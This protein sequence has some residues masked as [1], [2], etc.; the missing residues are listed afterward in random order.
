[1]PRW[2]FAF[3]PLLL[4]G[5]ASAAD[6]A[7]GIAA[8]KAVGREGSGNEAAAAGWKAVT[9]A[10][11]DALFPVLVA[12][13][14]ATPA[15][16]NWLRSTLDAIIEGEKKAGRKLP[17]AELEAFATDVKKPSAA[18]RIAFELVS[19]DA[20]VK[21]KL[22]AGML[23]DPNRELRR[24]AVAFELNK[25]Q[26]MGSGKAAGLKK[27]FAHAR[28]EDQ[29]TKLAEMLEPKLE[30]KDLAAHFGYITRWHVVGPFE[31]V[32]PAGF[33][34]AFAPEK[35]VKLDAEYPGKDGKPMRW[36]AATAVTDKEHYAAVNL[37]NAITKA[38]DSVAY[39]YTEIEV[40]AAVDVELRAS[41]PTSIKFFVNGA[42]VYAHDEY[43]HGS[44]HDQHIAPAKL[45]AGKNAILVKVCQNNQK[46]QWAQAWEFEV[47]VSD[48]TGGAVPYTI[49]SPAKPEGK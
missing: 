12:F 1:M 28:D 33:E 25:V 48:A 13:D 49:V 15:A 31:G 3:V 43:H 7:G 9:S 20:A 36:K 38:K 34:T 32:P 8:M 23:N 6:V 46:E 17:A 16:A 4:A 41:C 44:S 47:R 2:L 26:E 10:G 35:G 37:N 14:G 19:D 21:A 45:T 18:R 39:A 40:P 29:V 27:L 42:V 22:L 30:K 24:D 11:K 5:P